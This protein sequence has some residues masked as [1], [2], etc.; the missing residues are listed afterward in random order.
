MRRLIFVATEFQ[1]INAINLRLTLFKDD[2]VGLIV[3]SHHKNFYPYYQKIKDLSIFDKL[4]Y[5]PPK[6]NGIVSYLKNILRNESKNSFIKVVKNEIIE[7][8]KSFGKFF[9]GEELVLHIDIA[10]YRIGEYKKY[11]HFLACCGSDVVKKFY[12]LFKNDKLCEVS[13]LDEGMGTYLT[14]SIDE[15]I[16]GRYIVDSVY[17][18]APHLYMRNIKDIYKIPALSHNNIDFTMMLNYVFGLK[19]RTKKHIANKFIF[20][21]QGWPAMPAY[22]NDLTGI[23][24]IVL[25]NSYRKHLREQLINEEQKNLLEY[26]IKLLKNYECIVKFHPRTQVKEYY[27]KNINV[28]EFG[29]CSVPWEVQCCN[30]NIENSV[31]ITG[32]SSAVGL[33]EDT[34]GYGN[35]KYIFIY[36]LL[37]NIHFSNLE[38]ELFK[39]LKVQYYGR[40]FI[41]ENKEELDFI[42]N[43]MVNKS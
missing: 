12:N 19:N 36:K 10:G 5:M 42:L 33:Y 29:E 3:A 9:L 32:F 31:F 8:K 4:Y 26:I 40:V 22:L 38:H 35:N 23:K 15:D 13:L 6:R 30:I 20:F 17:V 2:Y 37:K 27:L 34:I 1:I 16:N 28:S 7:L 39:R 43:N 41:P 11:D 24:K 18:Y 25:K 21:E 14:D